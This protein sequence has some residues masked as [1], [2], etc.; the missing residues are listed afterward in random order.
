M[1]IT[2]ENTGAILEYKISHNK[3]KFDNDFSDNHDNEYD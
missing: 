3:N 1:L 2:D